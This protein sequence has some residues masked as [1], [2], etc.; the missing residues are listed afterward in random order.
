MIRVLWR[1]AALIGLLVAGLL[2]I[3]SFYR[4]LSKAGQASTR[5]AWSRLLLRVC[6]LRVHV[7]AD[8]HAHLDRPALIVLNHVSWL[9]IFVVNAVLP[10]TFVAKS[11]IRSWPLLG[12]L[13]SGTATIFIERGSRHA[14]RHANREILHRLAQG[15]HVAF[16]PEGTTTDGVTLLPF[17]ASLFAVALPDGDP[18][19]RSVMVMPAALR[20]AQAGRFS[21]IPAYTGD[22]TLVDSMMRILAAKGLEVHV[23]WLDPLPGAEHGT[24][25]HALA[26][27]SEQAIRKTLSSL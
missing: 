23:H 18:M 19:K 7:H 22:Q 4:F 2:I 17:H 1:L 26:Q 3:F 20:Y 25:R 16:F 12:W 8:P 24:T 27:Q 6:G 13:V 9:D 14:V 15:E 21:E 10:S 5:R 11:E